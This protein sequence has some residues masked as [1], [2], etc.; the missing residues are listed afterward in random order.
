MRS[1]L[2]LLFK[3]WGDQLEGNQLMRNFL[4]FFKS[5]TFVLGKIPKFLIM[6]MKGQVRSDAT[7]QTL[8]YL[9][10]TSSAT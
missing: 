9:C 3:Y 7:H 6:A 2:F 5:T 10:S 8:P 4:S 1:L